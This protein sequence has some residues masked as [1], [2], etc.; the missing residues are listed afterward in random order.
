MYVLGISCYYH[1]AAAC[2]LRDEQI[3][4]AAAEERFSREKHDSGFPDR[5][6]EYCLSEADID[7][8]DVDYLGF[9]EKPLE[10]FDRIIE[11]FLAV[12]P[13][14]FRTYLAGLPL[15]MRKRLWIRSDIRD[16]L[17]YN[18]DILFARHHQSHAA[19]TFYASPFEE[20]AI[21]T[22]DGVG[23]WTT[24]TWGVGTRD[25]VEIR[26]TID[27]P[28]SLGLLYS[29]FT[30]YLGFEVNN[31]EYKVMGLASYGDPVYAD[32]IR[33]ELIDIKADGSFRLDTDRFTYLTRPRMV[34]DAFADVFGHP[35]RDPEGELKAHH[36]D[37]AA[38]VQTVLEDVLDRLVR[39]LHDRTE[40][41]YLCMAGGVALNSVANGRILTEA[42]FEDTFI[43]PA[44]GDD[45]GAY[46]VATSIYHQALDEDRTVPDGRTE[47]MNGTYLG[48]AFGPDR[49]RS[50]VDAVDVTA[51]SFET[52]AELFAA[53]AD[54]LADGQ[55]VGIYQGRMEWGPRALG[56]RSILAD[57]RDSEM[58]TVVNRKIK[59]REGFRPFAPT[60]LADHASDYFDAPRESPYMLQ[61][62]DVHPAKR[63]EIPA[64]THVD[65]TARIQTIAREDNP[66]Y[67]DL[68]D[69][70][71]DRT[72]VPVVL[73]T[74]LNRRG[75][76]IVCTPEDAIDC[77]V[78]TKMDAMCLPD[79][80][81]L[82]TAPTDSPAAVENVSEP[83]D[84]TA[85]RGEGVRGGSL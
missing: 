54:R 62:F 21:L 30:D 19:S 27:F 35:R 50:A 22:V 25:G 70:F 42:P 45:G 5:A 79:A 48:P 81:L 83:A 84:G 68:I 28:H 60:V 9:Y 33:E 73:N 34:G 44:A 66:T 61:V 78:G 17:D 82:L 6:V 8:D 16:H 3:V 2:L 11:T 69:A 20:A 39:T 18:G 40:M 24:T 67:Y 77:F 7:I 31:G 47:R 75:E 37:I 12:A 46:G 53:T 41:D 65:G 51:D 57:P 43:Q 59:F 56:N 58:Q 76:P 23:E 52:T 63:D 38:S 71:H 29:A 4:A 1:D 64:V 36:F 15:W 26:E 80:G 85:E 14:G 55:V 74:S 32:R 13:W 72:G 10:K 49:V